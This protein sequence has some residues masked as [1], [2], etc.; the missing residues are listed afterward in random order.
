MGKRRARVR[1]VQYLGNQRGNTPA[2]LV[3]KECVVTFA[4]Q[5]DDKVFLGVSYP[6]KGKATSAAVLE[7]GEWELLSG[8]IEP[9]APTNERTYHNYRSGSRAQQVRMDKAAA[10]YG[11]RVR[12]GGTVVY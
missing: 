10:R 8:V 2:C 5:R 1:F 3:G 11:K 9:V 6:A 12:R 4:E 7:E